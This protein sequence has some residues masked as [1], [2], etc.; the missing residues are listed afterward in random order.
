MGW[1]RGLRGLEPVYNGDMKYMVIALVLLLVAAC[2]EEPDFK[3]V[4]DVVL[5]LDGSNID[6]NTCYANGTEPDRPPYGYLPDIHIT[7]M[8]CA[9]G[10]IGD[11]Y[12]PLIKLENQP[13]KLLIAVFSH[14]YPEDA[15]ELCFEQYECR[16]DYEATLV[17][18]G[19]VYHSDSE[20][21]L[22]K[23]QDIWVFDKNAIIIIRHEGMSN[24]A[25][26]SLYSSLK[27]D[28]S[29]HPRR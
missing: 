19:V 12:S 20:R 5:A 21:N 17:K 7:E 25:R 3:T 26:T 8:V 6:T 2:G 9:F 18:P 27:E 11:N 4:D 14:S 23:K 28:V 29:Q 15:K 10:E 24:E 22:A 16:S 1:A 13:L